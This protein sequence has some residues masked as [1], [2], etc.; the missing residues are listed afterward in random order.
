MSRLQAIRWGIKRRVVV[1]TVKHDKPKRYW[2]LL[3]AIASTRETLS[4][5]AIDTFRFVLTSALKLF[6][7]LPIQLLVKV[8][9]FYPKGSMKAP[10]HP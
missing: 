1:S 10:K 3:K 4:I 2:L 5:L 8:V 7:F 9:S 6:L